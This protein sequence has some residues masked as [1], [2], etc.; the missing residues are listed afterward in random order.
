VTGP[1]FD[2]GRIEASA[3]ID[4]GPARRDLAELAREIG[5]FE[6]KGLTL[7]AKLEMRKSDITGFRRE[8]QSTLDGMREVKLKVGFDVKRSQLTTLR[9]DVQALADATRAIE[10]KTDLRIRKA[11]INAAKSEAQAYLDAGRA[12]H[13][14]ADIGYLNQRDI[15]VMY[16][17]IQAR[18]N[19]RRPLMLQVQLD[20]EHMLR[21]IAVIQALIKGIQDGTVTID[22]DTGQAILAL[23]RLEERARRATRDRTLNVHANAGRTSRILA[24]ILASLLAIS[25]AGPAA[26]ASLMTVVGA[27]GALSQAG[28]AIFAGFRGIGE[29][30]SSMDSA[31]EQSAGGIARSA[32]AA[33]NAMRGLEDA[34][35]QQSRTARAGLESVAQAEKQLARAQMDAKRAQQD[36]NREREEAVERLEDLRFE[37][38]GGAL[39][40]RQAILDLREAQNELAQGI[41]AGTTGDALEQLK[42]NAERAQLALDQTRES[43][44]DLRKAGEYAARTGVEGDL[45]VIAAHERVR[46]A[47]DQ[48]NE[49]AQALMRTQIEAAEANAD[50]ARSV[51]EAQEGLKEAYESAG[52]AGSAAAR[53]AQEAYDKLTAEGKSFVD[54]TRNDLRPE[55]R[56]I[57][58]SVQ[59]AMLPGFESGLRSML[60]VFP[61]FNQGLTETGRIVGE[62]AERGGA[63]MSNG[64]WSEDWPRIM[65]INNRVLRD[66]GDIGL[67]TL[68]TLRSLYVTSGPLTERFTNFLTAE[69]AVFNGFIEGKRATGELDRHFFD[70][71]VRLSEL[72]SIV[73]DVITGIYNFTQAIQPVTDTVLQLVAELANLVET[74]SEN[75]GWFVQF[76]AGAYIAYRAAV[77]IATAAATA[78]TRMALL[79]ATLGTTGNQAGAAGGKMSRFAGSLGALAGVLTLGYLAWDHFNTST[80]EAADKMFQT[81]MSVEEAAR[82][83]SSTNKDLGEM[84]NHWGDAIQAIPVVGSLVSITGQHF[85]WFGKDVKGAE[86]RL[87]EFIASKTPLEQANYRVTAAQKLYNEALKNSGPNTTAAMD[88]QKLL[89]DAVKRQQEEQTKAAQ[90]TESATQALQ[91]QVDTIFNRINAEDQATLSLLD[92]KDA[93]IEFNRVTNDATASAD[94]RTRAQIAVNDQ[95]TQYIE[96]MAKAAEEQAKANGETDLSIARTNSYKDSLLNLIAAGIDPGNKAVQNLAYELGEAGLKAIGATTHVDGLGNVIAEI[97]GGP[98]KPPVIIKLDA[99]HIPALSKLEQVRLKMVEFLNLL[100]QIKVP[101]AGLSGLYGDTRAAGPQRYVFGPNGEVIDRGATYAKGGINVAYMANGGLMRGMRSDIADIVPPNL[102]R[103]MG[104]RKWGME[105]F[106]PNDGGSERTM[107]ILAEVARWFNL[108]LVPMAAGGLLAGSRGMAGGG[109]LHSGGAGSGGATAAP[110]VA[111]TI[112]VLEELNKILDETLPQTLVESK[113]AFAASWDASKTSVVTNSDQSQASIDLLMQTQLNANAVMGQSLTDFTTHN[114]N[115]WLNIDTASRNATDVITGTYFPRLIS[116][117]NSVQSAFANTSAFIG[118]EWPKIEAYAGNPIRWVLANPYN[119]GIIPAWNHIDTTFNLGKH[120]NDVPTFQSGGIMPGYDPGRDKYLIGVGGGE[121]IFRPEVTRVLG[122]ERVN[123]WNKA[124]RMGGIQG[125]RE[126][127]LRQYPGFGGGGTVPFASQGWDY[128]N[129]T[130]PG[131]TL[132]GRG[133]GSVSGSDHPKGLA[134]DVMIPNYRQAS[135]RALGDTIANDFVTNATKHMT[136]YVI[137][138][139]KI[140]QGAWGP[141]SHPSGADDRLAHRNHV[142]LSFLAPGQSALM[143][144]LPTGVD[145][146]QMMRDMFKDA[147]GLVDQIIPMWGGNGGQAYMPIAADAEARQNIDRLISFGSQ[148]FYESMA[149]SEGMLGVAGPAP[150]AIG[151]AA[152]GKTMAARYGWGGGPQW[153]ALYELWRRES[154]WNHL[155]RNPKS[156]AYGIPQSLP[157]SKMASS[158]PDY[159]TNPATQIDWGLKYIQ[160]RY[161]TP[162]GALGFHDAHNWYHSGGIAPARAQVFDNGGNWAPQ[163]WGFNATNEFE[164]VMRNSQLRTLIQGAVD[165]GRTLVM[166]FAERFIGD[167]VRANVAAGS[168][169]VNV[170]VTFPLPPNWQNMNKQELGREVVTAV[171]HAGKGGVFKP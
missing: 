24:I 49:A 28:V 10:L 145:I 51:I 126:A 74:L 65:G 153:D 171:R 129:A 78:R 81:G 166:E 18:L 92:A 119:K 57:G 169:E 154:S 9:R 47:N 112:P 22:A 127:V 67:S 104:D 91:R 159:L 52:S 32:S 79:G 162:M 55:M 110:Q 13:F 146:G 88:A 99:D 45:Q 125:V 156:G 148:Q 151:N 138:W 62:L 35:R 59:A 26:A 39:D 12:I 109:T 121:T 124:A 48:V 165:R 71:G 115:S 20:P 14:K 164:T 84:N 37:L 77:A 75:Y 150:N 61:L 141:Y 23:G 43:N 89:A 134:I 36:L 137:W 76:A 72:G 44:D 58:E 68:D 131:L 1:V 123:Y 100:E 17:D 21:Q 140:W 34:Q 161:G 167:L 114:Q 157:A 7:R 113:D 106:I 144:G 33:R 108:R 128:I 158:G 133:G 120:L 11:D 54:F 41:S 8:V 118:T 73:S 139:E 163:T 66:F 86:E 152:L 116:G 94:D 30:I 3:H 2:A 160:G 5:A 107:A 85:G 95:V 38:Q 111:E 155:A 103:V 69:M 96:N 4:K 19:A 98:G 60:T 122:K 42:I 27:A 117:L 102:L 142:H 70:M 90:A 56:K 170:Y 82:T 46:D 53:K 136:K 64:P 15:T 135:G 40:E 132:G 101:G 143:N 63:M 97:P 87:R 168:R 149:H 31:A 50:A 147:Y 93:Q 80:D 130:Y 25:A 16:A 83:I 6:R 105:A 29:A